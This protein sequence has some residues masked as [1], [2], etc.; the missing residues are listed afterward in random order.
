MEK[1]LSLLKSIPEYVITAY[2]GIIAE[3]TVPAEIDGVAVTGI[4]QMNRSHMIAALHADTRMPLVVICQDDM[5]AKRLQEELKAFLGI[6]PPVLPS[7]DL[8]LYD[9]AVVSRAWEQ[10]RLRQFYELMNGLTS[11][12]ILS[13]EALSQRTMPPTVLAGCAFTLETGKEYNLDALA[14]RISGAG[15]SRTSMV[16]GP[17]QFAVRGG[18]IDIFSPA[19][20][21][22]VRAEFFGEELDTMGY[23]DP[24]TQRRTENVSSV[25][26]LPV[27]ETQPRLHPQ[28]L[29]GL[30][31][32]LGNLIARQKRRKTPNEDLIKTL[33]RDLEKYQNGVQN[34]ASDRY[35]ALIYPEMA[36][37]MDYIPENAIVVLCDQ[38][39]L[40]RTARTRMDELG[41]Q[42]DSMLQGGLLAGTVR[43]CLPMGRFL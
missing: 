36:T 42:L 3:L 13:W 6:T 38:G 25:I 14:A 26:I 19:A 1:L 30:C 2:E 21:Y 31:D 10:K 15:Y 4:G 39:A 8:T 9:T 27:G 34:P 7:R 40:K 35:M 29:D 24:D 43:L 11:L 22:P 41:M 33:E 18:I 28:G 16:E 37:A 17:G 12:Q 23:F 20:D 5:A 32:D